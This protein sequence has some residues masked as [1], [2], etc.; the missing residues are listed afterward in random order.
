MRG[1][2]LRK[3]SPLL[4]L[5]GLFIA[6]GGAF[7]D[8]LRLDF[9]EPTT[10]WFVSENDP[11]TTS[12]APAPVEAPSGNQALAISGAFPPSIGVSYAPWQD[13]R[14]YVTLK[15]WVLVPKGA[16]KDIGIY[17]YLKDRQYLWYQTGLFRDPVTD[18]P[19][20][21]IKQGQWMSTTV[22]ISPTSR[23]WKPG[24]H[25]KSWY[26]TLFYPREF[27]IRFFSKTAWQ[28]TVYVDDICLIP[29]KAPS[30]PPA[31]PLA[32][33]RNADSLPCYGKFEL[34]FPVDREY[35]N[36]F[37]PAEVD[38]M[39]HFRTPGGKTVEVPGFF[40]QD[41][42]RV[43]D[44]KGNEKLIPVGEPS[45]K[46]RFSATE[47]GKH[48]YTVTLRDS[49]GELRSKPESFEAKPP[50]D[51]RGLVR[52]SKTDPRYFEFDNGEFF[53]PQGINMRDGGN[54]AS[55][56]RGTYAFDEYFPAFHQAGLG[57]VRTWMCAWWAGIEWSDKY[58]SRYDNLGRYCMYNAWRLD[59][60]M[61]LAEQNDLF[62]ELTLNSHGQLR[63]DKF[64]AEWE[65]NP[66]SAA[67]GGPC[68]TPSLVWS[69]P[70]AKEYFR[71]R[72]RYVV[73]RWGYS[74]H[75][76]AFDLWNE[77]D[78]IDGYGQLSP[79]VAAWHKEM[80]EYLRSIDPWRHL[81]TTHYCLHFSWDAGKSLWAVPNIDYMQAD[82][83]WPQKEIG[84]D[85]SRGYG[86]RADI[87]KPYMVI[88]Y[89][90]QT[91][92]LPNLTRDQIEGYFRI[93]LWTSAVTPM[94]SPGHFWYNDIWLRDGY[95]HHHAAL[96][97][98]LGAED[99]RGQGWTWINSDPKQNARAPKTTPPDL[100]VHAMKSPKATYFY[101]FDLQRMFAGEAGRKLTPHQGAT[102]DL[103]GLPDGQH[104]A[105]FWD[106]YIGEVVATTPVAVAN[107]QA[108]VPL[109]DFATDLACKMRLRA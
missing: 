2:A 92:Q 93:G 60:A 97:K 19:T 35:D 37:N 71:R 105:E 21:P 104:D 68:L 75:L 74:Q 56:Q 29:P 52:V 18:K 82:A 85:I 43:E 102:V 77:I 50:T 66:Y 8:I 16:P 11:G 63:R 83:Y 67:N 27:G 28:G 96:A 31:A 44:E 49:R 25:E 79:D 107:G 64:D 13:W 95:A 65:Y 94:A 38:V 39:G 98:F 1:R 55:Q 32:L 20:I 69:N 40:Y 87:D 88:E 10:D 54:L 80:S 91:A 99:R 5:M 22:D 100:F 48:E 62:V 51:P 84:D 23:A 72:Y 78:L 45:W 9:E 14:P 109:P 86:L 58:D 89:G 34:T 6:S 24:G 17:A 30:V 36:P 3:H 76:M 41:Y 7:S 108:H 4:V 33:E 47:P 106:P 57:Y 61:D 53:Y 42:R 26:R 59:R 81:I 46:V 70:T 12:V 15:V 90:P 101:V 103:Q 73:A